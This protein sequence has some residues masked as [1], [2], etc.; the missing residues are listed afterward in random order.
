M[1]LRAVLHVVAILTSAACTV[2]LAREYAARRWR[3]LLWSA[4]CF[5]GLTLNNVLIFVDLVL[6]PTADLR[7]ARLGASLAGMLLLLYGF[8]WESRGDAR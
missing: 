8:I 2:L 7:L 3:L 5:V 4:L 6:F 1:T